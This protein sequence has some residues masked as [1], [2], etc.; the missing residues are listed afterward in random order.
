VALYK[1][2]GF[3]RILKWVDNFFVIHL[4]NED[5]TEQ[6]FMALTAAFGV[7]WSANKMR[8]LSTVQRYIGFNW[9][10]KACTVALQHKKLTKILQAMNHDLQPNWTVSARDAASMHGKLVHVLCIFPLIRPFVTTRLVVV[11]YFMK[12]VRD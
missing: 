2:A 7:S 9:N 1:V 6:D 12:V 5:W 10:L 4:P 3:S 8:P 11:F